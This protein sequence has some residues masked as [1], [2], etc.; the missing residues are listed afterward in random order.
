MIRFHV[1]VT[2]HDLPSSV[3]TYSLIFGPP[4]VEKTDYAKR[5]PDG[6]PVIFAASTRKAA[7]GSTTWESRP[8]RTGSLR[9]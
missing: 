7:A 1:H 5:E 6:F 2:T 4:S 8:T 9:G 3:A